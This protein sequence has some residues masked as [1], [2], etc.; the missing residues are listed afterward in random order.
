MTVS[1]LSTGVKVAAGACDRVSRSVSVPERIEVGRHREVRPVGAQLVDGEVRI[2]HDAI[3]QNGT[4]A[5]AALRMRLRSP[6][7]RLP[8]A[9]G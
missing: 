1:P 8:S 2:R 5:V 3:L 7:V 6:T 4:G 9:S